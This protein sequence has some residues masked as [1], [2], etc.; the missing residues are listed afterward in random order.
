MGTRDIR[1]QSARAQPI[2]AQPARVQPVPSPCLARSCHA[3]PCP[4]PVRAQSRSWLCPIRAQFPPVPMP[5]PC[6]ARPF[7]SPIT[8]W[9][10]K[11]INIY[12][13]LIFNLFWTCFQLPCSWLFYFGSTSHMLDDLQT[14]KCHVP[15]K[16]VT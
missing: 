2:C 3:R 14:I 12:D 10:T 13:W 16:C 1:T 15:C 7:P 11:W 5:N 6:P 4:C 9:Q 8:N